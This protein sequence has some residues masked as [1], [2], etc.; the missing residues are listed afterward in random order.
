MH[1]Y[2]L[3]DV[4]RRRA[5][6]ATAVPSWR[7]RLRHYRHHVH[8]GNPIP[9]DPHSRPYYPRL[10]NRW[11]HH[12]CQRH[13]TGCGRRRRCSSRKGEGEGTAGD[14]TGEGWGG[15]RA[16]SSYLGVPYHTTQIDSG[17]HSARCCKVWRWA[18]C[19]SDRVVVAGR[20]L[21]GVAGAIPFHHC[22]PTCRVR[23]R[24]RHAFHWRQL[25]LNTHPA[26][27]PS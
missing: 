17:G 2:E 26:P 6:A 5:A 9:A 3:R 25:E 21:L 24:R 22:Y 19:R 10:S 1:H 27:A 11:F 16:G 14:C 23:Q 12:R 15:H 7:R 20:G 4:R 8:H 13:G 18:R